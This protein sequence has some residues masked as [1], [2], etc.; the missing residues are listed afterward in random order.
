MTGISQLNPTFQVSSVK[1]ALGRFGHLVEGDYQTTRGDPS[2]VTMG[3]KWEKCLL[4]ST[5]QILYFASM[6]NQSHSSSV[7]HTLQKRTNV[8]GSL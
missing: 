7:A 3:L 2:L 8:L 6:T 1:A 5:H 4:P